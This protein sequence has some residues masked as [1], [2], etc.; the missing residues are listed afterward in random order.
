MSPVRWQGLHQGRQRKPIVRTGEL[1]LAIALPGWRLVASM[2][3]YSDWRNLRASATALLHT[4]RQRA[5]SRRELSQLSE[6]EL[7]D[8]RISRCDA[9]AEA[10][11][12]FWRA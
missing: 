4:W 11:K 12:P 8:M 10:S 6:A 9:A 3:R 1:T 5:H 2:M 7:R